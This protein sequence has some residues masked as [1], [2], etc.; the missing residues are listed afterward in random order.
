MPGSGCLQYGYRG[1]NGEAAGRRVIELL[2]MFAHRLKQQR[3]RGCRYLIGD[4]L[5]AAD[6]Y[7]TAFMG[8]FAPLPNDLCPMP[9]TFRAAFSAMDDAT[10]V[11]LDPIL[12][13]HRDEIYRKHLEL[14]LTL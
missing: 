13:E 6:I 7:L 9:D 1:D 8:L 14:P 10:R 4:A 2:G 3:Q 11:A 5:T 12:L